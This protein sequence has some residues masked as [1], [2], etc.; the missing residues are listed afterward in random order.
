M[1]KGFG[2][3]SPDCLRK[4]EAEAENPGLSLIPPNLGVDLNFKTN[5]YL[6]DKLN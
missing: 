3:G 4:E 2:A 6:Y 1:H 5:F